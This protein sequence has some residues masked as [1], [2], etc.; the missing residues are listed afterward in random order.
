[1]QV[2]LAT[3]F[4]WHDVVTGDGTDTLRRRIDKTIINFARQLI[5]SVTNNEEYNAT[6][7][8][9][10]CEPLI[11]AWGEWATDGQRAILQSTVEAEARLILTSDRLLLAMMNGV[12]WANP[13][14]REKTSR[15]GGMQVIRTGG[16]LHPFIHPVSLRVQDAML[17]DVLSAAE[18]RHREKH[19][20]LNLPWAK[21]DALAEP[22]GPATF[23]S[24]PMI[25][26]KREMRDE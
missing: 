10:I 16:D 9:R 20:V 8:K 14:G 22:P 23:A 1:M 3:P 5:H 26:G 17:L 21:V 18:R 19:P 7:I 2:V 6:F 25:G 15:V 4:P 11:S 24:T 13:P 12:V